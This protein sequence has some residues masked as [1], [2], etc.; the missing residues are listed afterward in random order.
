MSENITSESTARQKDKIDIDA[1]LADK[2]PGLKKKLPQFM[3]R[4]LKKIAHQDDLN[5]FFRKY[6]DLYGADFAKAIL[7]DFNITIKIEGEENLPANGRVIFASN[8][9]LGGADGVAIL[10]FLS[11]HYGEAK[12]PVNDMLM[13]VENLADFFI[14]INKLGALAKDSTAMINNTYESDNPILFFP[15]GMVSRKQKGGIRDLEWKKTFVAKAIQY[16]RDIVPLHFVGYNSPFFY[17]LGYLRT[18][19]GIKVNIEMLYLV[20]EL[21]KQRNKT[22]TIRVGKP[23]SWTT[24]DKTKSQ[25]EWADWIRE[26]VY[27]L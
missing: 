24:F 26:K 10:K 27:S 12:A 18:K 15:A 22:F 1:I 19:L 20:D 23:I 4:Y 2:A 11:D 21:Y 7:D 16:E 13:H 8:H 17:N 6:G 14:P 25:R 3:I 5:G 9:P